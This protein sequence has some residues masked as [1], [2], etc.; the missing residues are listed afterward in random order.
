V[1]TYLGQKPFFMGTEPVG[2]LAFVV[3][4]AVCRPNTEKPPG[5]RPG[6]TVP[7]CIVC[8]LVGKSSH[9]RVASPRTQANSP[10]IEFPSMNSR[11]Y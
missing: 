6:A 3:D 5:A 8:L 1:A 10:R 2:A 11:L 9:I 7:F 4:I